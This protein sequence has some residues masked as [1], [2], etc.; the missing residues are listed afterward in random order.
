LDESTQAFV[1]RLTETK[2]KMAAI[3]DEQRS[4][5]SKQTFL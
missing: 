5:S 3:L 2:Y 1:V 4:W